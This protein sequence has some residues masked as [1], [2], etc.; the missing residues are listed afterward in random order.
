MGFIGRR[1]PLD[2]PWTADKNNR[3]KL[4]N[5]KGRRNATSPA[6]QAKTTNFLNLDD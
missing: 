4:L 2:W 3:K 1:Q 5:K 6:Q